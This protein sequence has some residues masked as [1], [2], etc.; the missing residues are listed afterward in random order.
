MNIFLDNKTEKSLINRLRSEGCIFAEEETQLLI[1]EAGS[2]EE[3]MKMVEKR[4][5]GFPLEY[6]LGFTKFCGIRIEIEQ[7]VFIPRRRTEFLVQQAKVLTAHMILFWIDVAGLVR[8][9]L[10]LQLL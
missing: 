5:C 9:V 7:G 10:Q 1:A 6:V 2:I 4:V 8:L 3:L